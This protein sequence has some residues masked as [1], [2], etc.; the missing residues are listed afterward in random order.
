LG[1]FIKCGLSETYRNVTNNT[2]GHWPTRVYECADLS[3]AL[4]DLIETEDSKLLICDSQLCPPAS[5]HLAYF[6]T[7]TCRRLSPEH[8]GSFAI[9]SPDHVVRVQPAVG[10]T[11]GK[12]VRVQPTVGQ[13]DVQAG[14]GH[15]G[16][17]ADTGQVVGWTD[18]GQVVGRADSWQVVTV[19]GTETGWCYCL[20]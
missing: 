11:V 7:V 16:E 18:T 14:S 8:I 6:G 1:T 19:V 2:R 4:L 15:V 20:H 10:V 3:S 13:G 17:Q 9:E 5:S 12:V